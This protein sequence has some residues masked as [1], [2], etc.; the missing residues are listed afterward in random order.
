MS[1]KVGISKSFISYELNLSLFSEPSGDTIDIQLRYNWY[2][3]TI[4]LQHFIVLTN[5]IFWTWKDVILY[6]LASGGISDLQAL[7]MEQIQVSR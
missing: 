4:P 3:D 6:S 5:G 2:N 7:E 1:K